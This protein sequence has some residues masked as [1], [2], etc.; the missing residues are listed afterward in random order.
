MIDVIKTPNPER[1]NPPD[2]EP[3]VYTVNYS[4][5]YHQYNPNQPDPD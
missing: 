4:T 5:I 3:I 2:P 1:P